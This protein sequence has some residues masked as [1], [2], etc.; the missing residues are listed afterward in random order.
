M[1][2]PKLTKK[3]KIDKRTISSKKNIKGALEV[4]KKMHEEQKAKMEEWGKQN[5]EKKEIKP[6]EEESDSYE[7]DSSTEE[8]VISKKKGG[9]KRNLQKSQVVEKPTIDIEPLSGKLKELESKFEALL[10]AQKPV[11]EAPPKEAP[12]P[13]HPHADLVQHMK[14]K[15]LNFD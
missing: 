6:I 14:F 10:S 15:I 4:R 8:I 11:K 3:G 13:V 2:Q 7:S 12:K 5:E 1:D 9:S